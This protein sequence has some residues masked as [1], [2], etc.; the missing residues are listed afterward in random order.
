LQD[1]GEIDRKKEKETERSRHDQVSNTTKLTRSSR[2]M[3]SR[4][5]QTKQSGTFFRSLYVYVKM[6]A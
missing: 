6:K 5:R 1:S 3:L 2:T 4:Q